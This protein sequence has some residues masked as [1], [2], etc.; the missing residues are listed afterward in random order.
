MQLKERAPV[1][2]IIKFATVFLL[3]IRSKIFDIPLFACDCARAHQ[4]APIPT[5]TF[6]P[7][8]LIPISEHSGRY[9]LERC[10]LRKNK[11]EFKNLYLQP[12]QLVDCVTNTRKK[13]ECVS[14]FVFFVEHRGSVRGPP[15]HS[16]AISTTF[17]GQPRTLHGLQR[18]FHGLP[19]TF[20]G[21]PQ[22]AAASIETPW[23]P[24]AL[25]RST[26]NRG[27]S[28]G[29]RGPST[30]FHGH[31]RGFHGMPRQ[32]AEHRAGP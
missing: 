7:V 31:S 18:T 28:T 11:T 19:R 15:R 20:Q 27:H 23:R 3:W 14:S 9:G 8:L 17:H 16:T 26:G 12:G 13:E 5:Y 22:N 10:T 30:G 32:I 24:M 4:K 29:Y 6:G 21:L 25:E 1:S 2:C